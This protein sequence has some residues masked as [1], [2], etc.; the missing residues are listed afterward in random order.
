M[1]PEYDNTAEA[2][3]VQRIG[4]GDAHALAEFVELKRP[5]LTAYVDRQLGSKLRQKVEPSDIVQEAAMSA[6]SGFAD[7]EFGDRDPFGWLCSLCDRRIVDAHRR[8]V[9]AQKRSAS[10]EVGLQAGK[11]AA[12]SE[13]GGLI[14]ILSV[15]LTSASSAVVR[16]ERA[17]RMRDMLLKL[18]ELNREVLKLRYVDGLPSK[19]IA[20]RVG[21]SD[22]ATR[23]LLTRSLDKLQKELADD[24]LFH[25][26]V[27][28]AKG[29]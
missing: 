1:P 3:L 28:A 21:K 20:D 16:D 27:N 14:D 2:D 8:Y 19:E 23:V 7:V 12:G 4:S 26:F 22:G 13:A 18:P 5:Q 29:R 11:A 17:V 25:T 9:G 10:K 15:S 24:D 6:L